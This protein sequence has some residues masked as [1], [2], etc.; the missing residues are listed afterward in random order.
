[1]SNGSSYLDPN[2]PDAVR[3]SVRDAPA[4]GEAA[5]AKAPLIDV[6]EDVEDYTIDDAIRAMEE[7]TAQDRADLES[8]QAMTE[9]ALRI[10]TSRSSSAY[11]RA[12]AALA[13]VM[14]RGDVYIGVT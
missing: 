13:F 8:D 5:S 12:L 6:A 10:L 14:A 3:L 11:S 2:R 4:L 1:M 7:K 9:E